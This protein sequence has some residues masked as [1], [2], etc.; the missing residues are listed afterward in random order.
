MYDIAI[1]V[2]NAFKRIVIRWMTYEK[3]HF[4]YSIWKFISYIA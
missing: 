3:G 4:C 2:N 1:L